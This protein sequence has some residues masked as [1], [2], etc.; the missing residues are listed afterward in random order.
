MCPT[1]HREG[2]R[3]TLIEREEVPAIIQIER[4]TEPF[5]VQVTQFGI[6]HKQQDGEVIL[7]LGA[8]L[9]EGLAYGIT[10]E[11]LAQQYAVVAWGDLTGESLQIQFEPP[12]I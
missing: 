3:S 2:E 9:Q 1:G 4:S 8:C 12:V 5:P 6:L 7:T 10:E 11:G